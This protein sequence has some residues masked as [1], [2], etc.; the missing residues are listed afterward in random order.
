MKDITDKILTD[1]YEIVW[2]DIPVNSNENCSGPYTCSGSE[3][4]FDNA[5]VDDGTYT[6]CWPKDWLGKSIHV[7][8]HL[9]RTKNLLP[10]NIP[11]L[12]VSRQQPPK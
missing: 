6:Y 9:F 3:F 11:C 7:S 2:N 10:E 8:V 12:L 4:N 1:E 5:P